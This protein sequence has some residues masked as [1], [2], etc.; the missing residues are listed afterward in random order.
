MP[1]DLRQQ[2]VDAG[3][4]ML[5]AG[6]VA[7]T[8]GNVSAREGDSI[9]ITPS[10][11]PYDEIGPR[12]LIRLSLAGEVLEGGGEPS[13]ERRVHLA[14]YATRPDA[15]AIAHTHS[16]HATAWSFLGEPL[17]LDTEELLTAAGGSV[18]CAEHGE[19]GSDELAAIVLA[20]CAGRRAVLMARHGV[21]A[22]GESPAQ[23]LDVCAVVERQAEIAWLLRNAGVSGRGRS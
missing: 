13:S 18:R 1:T 10:A 6:L 22:L 2:I 14:L 3:R 5:A 7:G 11:V 21:V 17:D 20:A 4:A 16:V 9:L 23:A 8:S 19:S 12:D 15:G